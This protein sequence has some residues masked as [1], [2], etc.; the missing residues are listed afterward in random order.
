MMK[1]KIV[2]YAHAE[3]GV[4]LFAVPE[5]EAERELLKGLW[6]HGELKVCNGVADG[7]GQGFCVAWKMKQQP[8]SNTSQGNSG[9]T[10]D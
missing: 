2:T 5:T 8:T 3:N 4:S 10:N 1:C 9:E 7:S 6:K